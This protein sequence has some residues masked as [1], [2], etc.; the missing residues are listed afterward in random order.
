VTR[1]MTESMTLG[2]RLR[3]LNEKP[4]LLAHMPCRIKAHMEVGASDAHRSGRSTTTVS[5][6][7]R[8]HAGT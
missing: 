2:S 6:A 1:V 7:S 3:H 5:T 8:T 4:V